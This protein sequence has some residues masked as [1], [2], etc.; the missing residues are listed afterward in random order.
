MIWFLGS[1]FRSLETCYFLAN[2]F[3]DGLGD[4]QRKGVG[5]ILANRV[6]GSERKVGE[7]H[8]EVAAH[9]LVSLV[10]MGVA[11]EGGTAGAGTPTRWSSAPVMV[12]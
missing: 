2:Q 5:R 10:G 1:T 7:G 3:L 4:E 12:R 11:G 8:M 6:A 9:L